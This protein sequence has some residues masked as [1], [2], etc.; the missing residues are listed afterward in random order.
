MIVL[1]FA[2]FVFSTIFGFLSL[3]VF[4]QA[5]QATSAELKEGGAADVEN[6]VRTVQAVKFQ[7]VSAA[8]AMVTGSFFF[9]AMGI[10]QLLVL[11]SRW[12]N[13]PRN[14]DVATVSIFTLYVAVFIDSLCN[15]FC[16]HT[17]MFTVFDGSLRLAQEVVQDRAERAEQE[18]RQHDVAMQAMQAGPTSLERSLELTQRERHVRALVL[19]EASSVATT[20]AWAALRSLGT[21]EANR[22]NQLLYCVRLRAM[23]MPLRYEVLHALLEIKPKPPPRQHV[24]K[25]FL[26]DPS[27][28]DAYLEY[29][30]EKANEVH[31][32]FINDLV[33]II[34]AF[35]RASSPSELGLDGETYPY[36]IWRETTHHAEGKKFDRPPSIGEILQVVPEANARRMTATLATDDGKPGYFLDRADDRLLVQLSG[37]SR[38]MKLPVNQIRRSRGAA[39]LVPGPVKTEER[40]REKVRVD[41]KDEQF[42]QAACLLDLVRASIV[43]DDPYALA[44]CA[45][46]L[47]R[48]LK[49]IR[50]K[51]RF[52]SDAIETVGVDRLLSEF[53]AAETA[54]SGVS[55]DVNPKNRPDSYTQ[56]Y[57]DV[58]LVIEASFPGLS[59][60]ETKFLCEVQLTLSPIA[61]LKKS[62]QKIYSLMRMASPQELRD[63]FVFSRKQEEDESTVK[64]YASASSDVPSGAM[65]PGAPALSRE[66]ALAAA[67]LTGNLED[68]M[69]PESPDKDEGA[70]PG[71]SS[72]APVPDEESEGPSARAVRGDGS[73]AVVTVV[74]PTVLDDT[75]VGPAKPASKAPSS[76]FFGLSCSPEPLCKCSDARFAA[77]TPAVVADADPSTSPEPRVL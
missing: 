67:G 2:A 7:F 57:R 36:K 71:D 42:P 63:Q 49:V 34:E 39:V 24:P 56:Q 27:A 21:A 15:D 72:R 50:L 22:I 68:S 44:V 55:Q 8:G 64:T 20:G 41:Y 10:E 31:K 43:L 37:E 13:E 74:T 53:Y 76:G 46:Y 66:D 6:L 61:I 19:Q 40:S 12:N 26:Q 1:F 16:S 30:L 3:S 47:R 11:R 14:Q 77:A 25:R 17:M 38:P 48:E 62:E 54:G 73:R 5:W 51:N 28:G 59:G 45:E 58:N 4:W 23:I 32:S 9:L 52:A 70:A 33:H 18:L 35:N 75:P 60:E 69:F 65:S 29:L